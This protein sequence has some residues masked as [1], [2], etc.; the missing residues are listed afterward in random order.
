MHFFHVIININKQPTPTI[1]ICFKSCFFIALPHVTL[2][3]VLCL[4]NVFVY[5]AYFRFSVN[6]LKPRCGGSSGPGLAFH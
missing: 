2:V 1:L 5:R 6:A 4:T 3:L